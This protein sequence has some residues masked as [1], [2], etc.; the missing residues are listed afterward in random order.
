MI[1]KQL[2]IVA[3]LIFFFLKMRA[4]FFTDKTFAGHDFP[5]AVFTF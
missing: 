2:A 4:K 3:I 5:W 1:F